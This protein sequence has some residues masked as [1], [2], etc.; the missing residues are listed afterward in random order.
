[1]AAWH[2]TAPVPAIWFEDSP[3]F[4]ITDRNASA[5]AVATYQAKW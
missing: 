5:T 2:V 3:A 4:D 1:M